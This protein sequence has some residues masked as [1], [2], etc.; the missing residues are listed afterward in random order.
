MALN[1]GT[2]VKTD[3]AGNVYSTGYFFSVVDFDPGVGTYTM[4]PP[5]TVYGS[6]AYI[7][8]LSSTG[9]L[10]WAKQI[11]GGDYE[12]GFSLC[13]D[14]IG[15]I[16]T[17]GYFSKTCDFD[18]GS[19]T[20]TLTAV[21]SSSSI[22]D[23]YVSKLD[24]TGNFIW[25]KQ[26]SGPKQDMGY[27]ILSD[28][29]GN[30][31]VSG[32]F[33]DTV[34]FDPGVGTFTL[35]TTIPNGGGFITKLDPNGNFIWS[36]QVGR[37]ANV[38][39]A[40][41]IELDGTGNIL[42]VGSFSGTADFD[43]G[44]L[45]TNLSSTAGYNAFVLKLDNSGNFIWVKQF[46][47]SSSINGNSIKIDTNNNCYFT[48]SFGGTIDF[49]PSPSVYTLT[50]VG[51][52]NMYITKLDLN[53]NLIWVDQMPGTNSGIG[54][55]LEI[56]GSGI[57]V[58]GEH[59]GVTDFD[60]SPGTFTLTS[61]N[62]SYNAF[63][64]KLDLSGNL[65]WATQP[66]SGA[67]FINSTA[68]CTDASNNVIVTGF[69]TDVVDFDFGPGTY[70][71]APGGGL[72][73]WDLYLWKLGQSAT[74]IRT[75]DKNETISVF[76]N[77]NNGSFN[78]IIDN[79]IRNGEFVLYNS[80]GQKVFSQNITNGSNSI[81]T[82]EHSKGLYHYILFSDSEKIYSGKIAIE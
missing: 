47:G 11:G 26:F 18:P 39:I 69:F 61:L 64:T 10:I 81:K 15:N 19:G 2:S 53:G 79:K 75:I 37:G 23:V 4:N 58:T 73:N 60:P 3:L 56:D 8:K 32:T 52:S 29:T 80:I 5:G 7:S 42:C 65:L 72:S 25:A 68:I 67:N 22:A 13:L 71:L 50:C 31:Y 76:P 74:G 82:N 12:Q 45:T 35:G 24:P 1:R 62:I 30:V 66:G 46:G 54:K 55:A 63:I 27:A 41:K 51:N 28:A 57:Y 9:N 6:D 44:T 36:K 43:P 17:T 59:Q 33:Q 14:P 70:T 16:Y 77:P 38:M 49:D 20:Y 34:D 78:I 40:P 21:N 48:G